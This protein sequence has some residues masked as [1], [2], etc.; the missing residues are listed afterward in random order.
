MKK[1]EA[2]ELK[3]YPCHYRLYF[4]FGLYLIISR[5]KSKYKY[6]F[7]HKKTIVD[8]GMCCVRKVLTKAL[9]SKHFDITEFVNIHK[10]S[11]VY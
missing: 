11:A 4:P 9:K 2:M 1:E 5:C 7:I 8:L 6:T 10:T 3:K